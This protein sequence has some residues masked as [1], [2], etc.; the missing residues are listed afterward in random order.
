MNRF[1]LTILLAI[2]ALG[3][4]ITGL[5]LLNRNTSKALRTLPYYRPVEQGLTKPARTD[6]RSHC[7]R[8]FNFTDQ[9]GKLVTRTDYKDAIV[10][11]DFFFTTCEG[12]CPTMSKQMERVYQHYYGKLNIQ[13]LS[14]TVNP[15][16]DSVP[17]MA[18]YAQKHG[19]NSEQWKFVTGNKAE[20][21]EMARRWYLVSDTEGDGS[22]ED[23]VHSPYFALVDKQGHVR[24]HYDGTDTKDVDRLITD[25][26]VLLMESPINQ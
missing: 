17:V 18:A 5:T 15:E 9:T 3:I 1:W 26:N 25:I 12:I 19:A 6:G 21:Y 7:I 4:L 10:I 11:V 24:G 2:T 23:F 14:H 8:D 13:F 20:I 16:N 22:R